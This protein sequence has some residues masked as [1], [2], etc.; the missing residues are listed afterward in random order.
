MTRTKNETRARWEYRRNLA[1]LLLIVAGALSWAVFMNWEIE[2]QPLP[3]EISHAPAAPEID[4]DPLCLVGQEYIS[5]KTGLLYRCGLETGGWAFSY[6][7]GSSSDILHF[8]GATGIAEFEFS[9][10]NNTIGTLDIY[11]GGGTVTIETGTGSFID[12]TEP[13]ETS[14]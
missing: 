4:E 10:A 5:A 6:S 3:Y 11:D 7:I 12:F 2:I 9:D 1:G 13:L 14:Q 8:G